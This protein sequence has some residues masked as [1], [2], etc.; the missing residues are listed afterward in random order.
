M[1]T[2]SY[3]TGEPNVLIAQF[4]FTLTG[5]P[6]SEAGWITLEGD[7]YTAIMTANDTRAGFTVTVSTV[8][9]GAT[10]WNWNGVAAAGFVAA[11]NSNGNF[12]QNVCSGYLF[13][14]ST[15]YT[16]GNE[17]LVISGLT[18]GRKYDF[19]ILM[20]RTNGSDNRLCDI[21]CVDNIRTELHTNN[22]SPTFTSQGTT[23]NTVNNAGTSIWFRKKEAN[24]SGQV[25][26][27]IA[28][29][30][31]FT[32]GYINAIRVIQLSRN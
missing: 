10:Y 26:F 15:S 7:P 3:I 14:Q 4:N 17:N 21:R 28:G 32:F 16:P 27:H 25:K 24:G 30:P 6:I 29:N 1:A 19:E 11:V 18:S 2:L 5:N 9:T 22:A 20:C 12:P 13:N 8:G 31:G 23:F